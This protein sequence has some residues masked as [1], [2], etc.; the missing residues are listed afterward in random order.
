MSQPLDVGPAVHDQF[1]V[2]RPRF[3]AV[4]LDLA[5]GKLAPGG[6]AQDLTPKLLQPARLV[7]DAEAFALLFD[8]LTLCTQEHVGSDNHARADD[9]CLRR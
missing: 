8:S 1:G 9:A 6:G 5:H 4:A 3:E 7:G 2:N